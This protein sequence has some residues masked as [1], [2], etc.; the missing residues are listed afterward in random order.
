MNNQNSNLTYEQE[1]YFEDNEVIENILL[2]RDIIL[3]KFKDG[4]VEKLV[5]IWLNYYFSTQVERESFVLSDKEQFRVYLIG[6]LL[7]YIKFLSNSDTKID[8]EEYNIIKD[9]EIKYNKI[10]FLG[11]HNPIEKNEKML[12]MQLK[13]SKALSN[14]DNVVTDT[15]QSLLSTLRNKIK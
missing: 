12:L 5:D 6:Q 13:S 15:V 3:S 10:I 14:K 2:N 8:L 1:L 9:I 4:G 11:V 7:D